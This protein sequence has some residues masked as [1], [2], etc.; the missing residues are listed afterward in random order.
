MT[1]YKTIFLDTTPIIYFLDADINYAEKVKQI[2]EKLIDDKCSMVTSTITCTEYLTQPYKTGNTE[3]INVFFEFL[4]DCNIQIQPIDISIAKKAARI[5][6][7]YK[8]FK[9]MDCLQLAT[10]CLQQCD[11]FLT[12]DKQLR[13]FNELK[14]IVIDD[15]K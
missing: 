8:D 2:F 10:A 3:K 11:L 4:S 6:A 14:C 1:E 9:T 5:R 15:F 13:Q 12:N 7:E